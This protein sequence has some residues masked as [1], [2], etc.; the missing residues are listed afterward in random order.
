MP[1]VSQRDPKTPV[2][3]GSAAGRPRV[4]AVPQSF[5][6]HLVG[7]LLQQL[8]R[9]RE[10]A[11]KGASRALHEQ[12]LH[13]GGWA[14]ELVK[15]ALELSRVD[16]EPAEVLA[17]RNPELDDVALHAQDVVEEHGLQ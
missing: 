12:A 5:R 7:N 17:R 16:G 14:D 11:R 4:D 6:A 10:H 15:G 3:T 8:G 1:D 2:A 9:H 13:E